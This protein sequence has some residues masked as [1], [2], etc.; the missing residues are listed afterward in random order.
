MQLTA[1]DYVPPIWMLL[2]RKIK[3]AAAEIQGRL[4]NF[5]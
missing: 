5:Q 4:K 2:A 3:I 1:G